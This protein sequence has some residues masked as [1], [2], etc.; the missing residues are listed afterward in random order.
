[1]DLYD[2]KRIVGISEH[3][4]MDGVKKR[5]NPTYFS[6]IKFIDDGEKVNKPTLRF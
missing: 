1:M 3:N 2:G 6:P 5:L 4:E